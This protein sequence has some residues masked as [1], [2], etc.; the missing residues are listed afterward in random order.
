MCSDCRPI[1]A[2]TVRYRYPIPRL[3]DMLDEL[4]GAT[5]FSKIDLK[6]GYYQIRIQ[7]GD[8]WKTIFKT[9]FGKDSGTAKF[10][11]HIIKA[12]NGVPISNGDSIDRSTIG[13][14]AKATV[15]FWHKNDRYGT[16]T[17]TFTHMTMVY[18]MLYLPLYF[19]GF[20]GVD[21]VGSFVRKRC[22]RDEVD[23]VLNAS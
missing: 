10:I 8:E 1:N 6:S 14:H 22:S 2:I 17:Q 19:F 12:W 21:A 4:S 15:S 9:K 18:E 5:I 11:K 20:F 7:E 13:A 16:R 3:D 23:A